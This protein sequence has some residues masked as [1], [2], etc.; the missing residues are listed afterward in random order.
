MK[1]IILDAYNVIH[2]I[3]ELSAKLEISLREARRALL[4]LMIDWKRSRGYKGSICVVYDGQDGVVNAEGSKSW[5]I[6]CIFTSS[7]EEADDRIISMVRKAAKASEIVVVSEDGKVANG[8]KVHGAKVES[9]AFL[10]RKRNKKNNTIRS[11]SKGSLS[12][13]A[14]REIDKYYEKAL[15]LD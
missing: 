4:N 3:P 13:K 5:G 6:K 8:C 11:R 2:R 12:G 15:G 14:E 1:T 10:N 7:K 9:T